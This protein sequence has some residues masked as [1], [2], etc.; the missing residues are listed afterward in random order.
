MKVTV[1]TLRSF[2]TALR[3]S[4]L[5]YYR[6]QLTLPAGAVHGVLHGAFKGR[7]TAEYKG[8]KLWP[9]LEQDDKATLV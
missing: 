8:A 1:A 3:F 9:V 5:T 6:V 4:T 2:N 7:I